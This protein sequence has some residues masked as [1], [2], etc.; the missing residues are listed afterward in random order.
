MEKKKFYLHKI[1][2]LLVIQKIVTIHYQELPKDYVFAGEAHN[3][4]EIIYCD[5]NEVIIEV[6]GIRRPLKQGEIIFLSPNE[7]HAVYGNK[8][9][10]SN[11]FVITF[12]CKSEIMNYF[13]DKQI[14]LPDHLK[15]LLS[16]IIS[17]ASSTFELPVF[18]PDLKRLELKKNPALGGEQIIKN[19]LEL[20]LIRIVR[21]ESAKPSSEIQFI[22]KL[23]SS[24]A[25]EDVVIKYLKGNLY[26]KITLEDLCRHTNYGKT[27]LCT[28]FKKKTG[29]TIMN[30]FLKL[31]IEEA[32]KLIRRGLP[33]VAIADQLQFVSLS[34][35]TSTFK[36]LTN[37]SPSQYKK[38]II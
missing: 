26:S 28:E 24:Q 31:K 12:V 9:D 32:K 14:R 5:K 27:H 11:I 8:K 18:D 35:F 21:E 20:L 3:F 38:S 25:I 10:E 17:E 1:S 22:S 34:H 2:N 30:F 23:D 16:T 6:G 33:F 4:W 13:L 36:R 15:D 7:P 19:S 29:S 37:M